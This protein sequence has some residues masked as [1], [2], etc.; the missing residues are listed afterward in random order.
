MKEAL[1]ETDQIFFYFFLLYWKIVRVL[2]VDNPLLLSPTPN[3]SSPQK[4]LSLDIR[5]TVKFFNI[6]L[7]QIQF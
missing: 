3:T 5:N 1:L 2:G 6:G 4:K 7:L